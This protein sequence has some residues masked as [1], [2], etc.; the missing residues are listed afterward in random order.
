MLYNDVNINACKIN[1]LVEGIILGLSKQNMYYR[2]IVKQMEHN[3][4]DA[5]VHRT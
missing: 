5:T 1:D 3:V 4:S 2:N